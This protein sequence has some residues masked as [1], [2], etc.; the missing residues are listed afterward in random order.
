MKGTTVPSK[1]EKFSSKISVKNYNWYSNKTLNVGKKF[2]KGTF[3]LSCMS[4]DTRQ[5]EWDEPNMVQKEGIKLFC[6]ILIKGTVLRYK[7]WLQKMLNGASI[8]MHSY[9]NLSFISSTR[10]K[11]GGRGKVW[12][13]WNKYHKHSNKCFQVWSTWLH[14]QNIRAQFS[15]WHFSER[16]DILF[17]PPTDRKILARRRPGCPWDTILGLTR[18]DPAK[19]NCRLSI[20]HN[21]PGT[22]YSSTTIS[23]GGLNRQSLPLFPSS[24]SVEPGVTF[25]WRQVRVIL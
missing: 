23:M 2:T 4:G 15:I 10:M 16:N 21:V 6:F 1:I 8:K 20:A 24:M 3:Q 14:D 25:L 11:G 7:L 12:G 22:R 9:D 19:R 17:S 18:H 13:R 5:I